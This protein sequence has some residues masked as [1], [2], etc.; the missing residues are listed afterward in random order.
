MNCVDEGFVQFD[1]FGTVGGHFFQ[2]SDGTDCVSVTTF[3]FPDGQWCT[4][5]SFTGQ[6][7]VDNVFQEVAETAFFMLSGYQL[8]VL[9]FAT[10]LSRSFVISMNH[11]LLA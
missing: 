8:M 2:F 4:P 9:L 1:F 7:P 10:S 11:V 5:V 3:T 6:T